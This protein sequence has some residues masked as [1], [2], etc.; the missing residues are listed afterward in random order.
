MND[1]TSKLG[2]IMFAALILTIASMTSTLAEPAIDTSSNDGGADN[3]NWHAQNTDIYQATLPFVA[4]YSG[5]HSLNNV[6]ETQE[7]VSVDLDVGVRPWSGAE[8]HVDGLMWQGFGLSRTFGVV[9]FPNGEAYK[10]GT[11]APNLM[12]SRLFVRQTI[13]LGGEQEDVPDGPLTLAG[14]QDISRL[15][16]TFGRMSFLD[17][18]D[19]NTY[20]GD[21]RTQFMNW[22]LMANLTW[23]YGQDTIGYGTGATVELN[24]PNWTLRYGFFQMPAYVNTGNVGSGNGGEDQILAWPARGKYAPLFKS[25]SMATELEGRY[26]VNAHPGAIR[27]L[28]WA[29]EADDD[30]YQE[31][32]TILRANGPNADIS[33]AQAYHYSYGFGLNW[34]QEV[35]ENVGMFSRL[36][37]NDG[38]SQA[39]EFSDA[40]W[41]ASLGIQVKG[42]YWN[43]PNDT[44]GL[45]GVVSGISSDNQK[46]LAAGGF[47]IE[48]GDGALTYGRESV[49]E[50]YYDAEL[51]KGIHGTLDYQYIQNPAFN[52]D[53][54]RVSV[55]GGRIHAEF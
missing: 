11:E 23:D 39:L 41:S 49:V 33:P 9:A 37:W 55:F 5:P 52:R 8:F 51:W 25:W 12:F 13:G 18:F 29:D 44:V 20:A 1:V 48:D 19:H 22:A 50:T 46:F 7:T 24:Q 17:V 36:G 6:G 3:W 14:S 43:R 54:G 16:F 40:N 38:R 4:K 10:A 32:A 15:T 28:A 2:S 21:P 27:F 34:E 31:A 42:G 35:I 53:R 47:G 45:G 30:T 26:G